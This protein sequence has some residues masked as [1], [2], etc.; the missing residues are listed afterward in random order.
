MEKSRWGRQHLEAHPTPP[1]K[2]DEEAEEL[3]HQVGGRAGGCKDQGVERPPPSQ[4]WPC[5]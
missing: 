3:P 2:R 4:P 5:S 1:Q